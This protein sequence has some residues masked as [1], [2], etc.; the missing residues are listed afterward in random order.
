MDWTVIIIVGIAVVAL[1]V[2]LVL[3]NIRDKKELEEKIKRDY[4][5]PRDDEG[6][7]EVEDSH[8]P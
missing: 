4:K 2:F 8:R 6:D 3:R 7:I 1:V 5:K